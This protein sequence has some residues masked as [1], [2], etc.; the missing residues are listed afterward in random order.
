MIGSASAAR[1]VFP[2]QGPVP[3]LQEFP[4]FVS[5]WQCARQNRAALHYCY[6]LELVLDQEFSIRWAGRESRTGP[7]EAKG[8]L[9]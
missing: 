2:N 9:P 4:A 5:P 7:G 6:W 3:M 1:R 8:S